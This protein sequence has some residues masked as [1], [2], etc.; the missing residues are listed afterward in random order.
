MRYFL[1]VL[2]IIL[3]FALTLQ[4]Q[5]TNNRQ[6]LIYNGKSF[7]EW[8]IK[9]FSNYKY[10]ITFKGCYSNW[11]ESKGFGIDAMYFNDIP[12]YNNSSTKQSIVDNMFNTPLPLNYNHDFSPIYIPP[13]TNFP[14]MLNLYKHSG[15][16]INDIPLSS[17]TKF[18]KLTEN[19]LLH[20]YQYYIVGDDKFYY[21]KFIDSLINLSNNRTIGIYED[22]KGGNLQIVIQKE[23]DNPIDTCKVLV[24]YNNSNL[25]IQ[26]DLAKMVIDTNAINRLRNSLKDDPQAEHRFVLKV[27]DRFYCPTLN[28]GN[29]FENA[30]IGILLDR[31]G[32][33]ADPIDSLSDKRKKIEAAKEAYERLINRINATNDAF[34]YTFSDNVTL[35]QDWTNDFDLLKN[36]LKDVKPTG[37]TSLYEA[38]NDGLLKINASSSLHKVLILLTDGIDESN[39]NTNILTATLRNSSNIP[40]Y[41]IS[42]GL[43]NS[44]KTRNGQKMLDSLLRFHNNYMIYSV[45]NQE[46]LLKRIDSIG[47]EALDSLCCRMTLTIPYICNNPSDRYR[48]QLYYS[49]MEKDTTII[50]D[51]AN[52]LC[53]TSSRACIKVDSL[54]F[55]FTERNTEKINYLF[56]ENNGN[57]NLVVDSI[58]GFSPP[59]SIKTKMPVTIQP[60]ERKAL[61]VWFLPTEPGQKSPDTISYYQNIV[62]HSNAKCGDSLGLLKGV[63]TIPFNCACNFYKDSLVLSN[64]WRVAIHIDKKNGIIFGGYADNNRYIT[65][66]VNNGKNWTNVFQLQQDEQPWCFASY[67]D[68]IITGTDKGRIIISRQSGDDNT[69]EVAHIFPDNVGKITSLIWGGTHY[70]HFDNIYAGTEKNGIYKS[71]DAGHSWNPINYGL[72]LLPDVDENFKIIRINKQ[73]SSNDT[74]I[75]GA[76]ISGLY[77]S[78]DGGQNWES[79]Y[80]SLNIQGLYLLNQNIYAVTSDDGDIEMSTNKGVNWFLASKIQSK[81]IN[82]IVETTT[83]KL[84]AST[85]ERNE[86]DSADKGCLYYSCNNGYSW[87]KVFEE[88]NNPVWGIATKKARYIN[89]PLDSGD[90]VFMAKYN[91][92][93]FATCDDTCFVD[94]IMD[95]RIYSDDIELTVSPNPVNDQNVQISYIL[96]KLGEVKIDLID[97]LGNIISKIDNLYSEPGTYNRRYNLKNLNSGLYFIRISQKGYQKIEKLIIINND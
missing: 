87:K 56:V 83:G 16:R 37:G 51:I 93:Y 47:S 23:R 28:C 39:Y 38:I 86:D 24:E 82:S 8:G 15:L 85:T 26:I 60:G 36:K 89:C 44:N 81:T 78:V 80:P 10:K 95:N 91:G 50:Y 25:S 90:V 65:R 29:S 71:T 62:V 94:K 34:L 45:N 6:I 68:T 43:D 4:A 27:N 2:L 5:D 72:S 35:F 88:D 92:I 67:Q 3:S 53:D 9:L 30:A 69:W 17:F 20:Y 97:N 41:I 19:Q 33:M 31:S 77:K 59:F 48:V 64:A 40:I 76:K 61:E 13:D 49:P 70:E 55:A 21:F 58:T 11:R 74:L 75:A 54:F 32:S 79:I 84:F 52:N 96:T 66:S 18:A 42:L 57:I 22:N 46:D 14:Y 63:E 12:L 7:D 73:P 1:L